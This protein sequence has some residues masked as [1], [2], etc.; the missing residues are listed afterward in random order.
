MTNKN[1][2]EIHV[3]RI[4]EDANTPTD[5]QFQLW[6]QTALDTYCTNADLNIRIID[7]DESAE[8]NQQFRKKSGATNILSFNYPSPSGE[9]CGDLVICSPLVTSEAIDYEIPAE[10]HWAHLVVHGCYHLLGYDHETDEDAA[11]MEPLE[12][13]ALEKLGY[14]NPY[15]TYGDES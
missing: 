13:A 10:H 12:I 11:K 3:Q 6:V 8:L 4:F 2:I 1:V 5:E 14:P 7:T 9:L 15:D